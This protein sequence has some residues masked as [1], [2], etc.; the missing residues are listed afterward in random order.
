[1]LIGAKI[2]A[3]SSEAFYTPTQMSPELQTFFKKK[4]TLLATSINQDKNINFG[5]SYPILSTTKSINVTTLSSLVISFGS[6]S[7]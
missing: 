2:T 3:G 1:L 4:N 6:N 5:K 7:L